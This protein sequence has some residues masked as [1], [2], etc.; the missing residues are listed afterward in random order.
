MPV[1]KDIAE[2][3][4]PAARQGKVLTVSEV[5][6]DIK[7]ILENSFPEIWI[8]GEISNF[9]AYPSGH[10]YFTLKDEKASLQAVIFG[11]AHKQIKFKFE[12]YKDI[13]PLLPWR[14]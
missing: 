7:L 3:S 14:R 10:F 6:Q 13:K 1:L 2:Q 9:K 4:L 5:S 8:E 11:A 12:G